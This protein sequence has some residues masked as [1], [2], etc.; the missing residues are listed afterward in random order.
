MNRRIVIDVS[1]N[2]PI[3]QHVLQ[4]SNA[5]ALICKATEGT[6]FHD[7]TYGDHRAIAKALGIPF[8]AY[9]FLHPGSRGNE[10]DFFL[11]YA[12][13]KKGDIQPIIDSEVRDGA[14]FVTVAARVDSCAKE[15]ERHGFRPIL[16][17]YTSFIQGL[18]AARPKLARLRV[19][20]AGYTSRRPTIGHGVTVIGWQFTDAYRVGSHEYDASRLYVPLDSLRIS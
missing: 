4:L 7:A 8:G 12:K 3:S 20:Q 16:Y 10:A 2:N 9:L 11:A 6:T 15:L 5:Q 17:S 14:S 19:L 13:P 18:V 1:N